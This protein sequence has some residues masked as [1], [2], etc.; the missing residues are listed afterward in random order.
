M[1]RDNVNTYVRARASRLASIPL[2]QRYRRRNR[3][4]SSTTINVSSNETINNPGDNVVVN[5]SSNQEP[6]DD[7]IMDA[8][9]DAI[10]DKDLLEAITTVI[11]PISTVQCKLPEDVIIKYEPQ[12]ETIPDINQDQPSHTINEP[13]N[14]SQSDRSIETTSVT[15]RKSLSRS[16]VL[17]QRAIKRHNPILGE[18]L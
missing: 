12:T 15:E 2:E 9:E 16:T 1:H 11:D 17:P 5:S 6:I 10:D 13:V 14:D 4:Q 18:R 8:P 3:P 7:L